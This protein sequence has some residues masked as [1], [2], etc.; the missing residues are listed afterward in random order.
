MKE[1]SRLAVVGQVLD[2]AKLAPAQKYLKGL[3]L[4][5]QGHLHNPAVLPERWQRIAI[6]GHPSPFGSLGM[7]Q[8]LSNSTFPVHSALLYIRGKGMT[9]ILLPVNVCSLMPLTSS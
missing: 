1:L 9:L 8:Q 2:S 6:V 4:S 3:E 7:S 5:L